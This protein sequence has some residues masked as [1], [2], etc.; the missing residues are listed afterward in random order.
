MKIS[1][2]GLM[3]AAMYTAGALVILGLFKVA[4]PDIWAKIPGLKEF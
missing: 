4:V 3:K 2:Q 1:A